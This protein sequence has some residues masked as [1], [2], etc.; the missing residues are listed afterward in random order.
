[1][2]EELHARFVFITEGLARMKDD[3]CEEE[4]DSL[5]IEGGGRAGRGTNIGSYMSIGDESVTSKALSYSKTVSKAR[6]HGQ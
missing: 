3:H 6:R 4:F 2:V 5:L 1:M